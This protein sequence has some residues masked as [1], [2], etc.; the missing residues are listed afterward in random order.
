[1]KII[2]FTGKESSEYTK[3][4]NN[5]LFFQYKNISV[6]K[7]QALD[8]ARDEYRNQLEQTNSK[9]TLHYSNEMPAVFNVCIP[10]TFLS[11]TETSNWS[12]FIGF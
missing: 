10:V 6:E 4:I 7:G 8:R 1:M 3:T 9:Q 5:L 12:C 11:A 2:K